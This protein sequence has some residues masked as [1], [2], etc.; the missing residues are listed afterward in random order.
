MSWVSGD[1]WYVWLRRL[2]NFFATLGSDF[3]F[4]IGDNPV[5]GLVGT[6]PNETLTYNGGNPLVSFLKYVGPDPLHPCE[7]NPGSPPVSVSNQISSFTFVDPGAKP[8]KGGAEARVRAGGYCT[9]C[10]VRR[11]ALPSLH[12]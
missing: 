2:A 7:L 12:P 11:R 10:R 3:S 5:L 4:D 6:P 8:V 9:V 1:E